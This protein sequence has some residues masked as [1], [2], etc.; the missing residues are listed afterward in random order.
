MDLATIPAL[1]MKRDEAKLR[2]GY[3]IK[4]KD[5]ESGIF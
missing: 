3:R 2:K 5:K 4:R 1:V